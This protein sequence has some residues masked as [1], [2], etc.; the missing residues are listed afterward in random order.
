MSK[1]PINL[2]IIISGDRTVGK[3][4]II[5]RYIED[6]FDENTIVTISP[7]FSK[8]VLKINEIT[9]NINLWDLPGQERNPVATN[10]FVKDSNG[11]IYCCDITNNLTRDNL[12]AWEETLSSKEAIDKIP[13]IIIENKCDLLDDENSYQD[14]INGLRQFS[15]KLGCKNFLEQ[16]PKMDTM[17]KK[18]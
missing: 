10:S 18:Q 2:K 12:T 13:K 9:F 4:S 15:K 1:C 16:V 3:T 14:D 8:K 5:A 6:K 7:L 11:I 17:L